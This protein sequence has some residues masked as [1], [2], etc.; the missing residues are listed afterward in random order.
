M[1]G[2]KPLELLNLHFLKYQMNSDQAKEISWAEQLIKEFEQMERCQVLPIYT[3]RS[4]FKTLEN[5]IKYIENILKHK[6]RIE[7]I[8]QKPRNYITLQREYQLI[9]L[10]CFE[11][12]K[13]LLE[14]LGDIEKD[15]LVKGSLPEGFPVVEQN[16]DAVKQL[17]KE[18][19]D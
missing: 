8:Q 4:D 5:T 15:V 10:E 6:H 17:I 19:Y 11:S 18:F 12:L 14:P 7:R 13:K 1:S 16:L 2:F 3:P 9:L